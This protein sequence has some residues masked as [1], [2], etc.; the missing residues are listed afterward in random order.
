MKITTKGFYAIEIMRALAEWGKQSP[1][2]LADVEAQT[3][4][5]RSYVALLTLGLKRKGLAASFRGNLA[6]VLRS[7]GPIPSPP[8]GSRGTTSTE[9]A[10]D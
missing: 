8:A 5:P 6:V 9:M 3:G 7:C 2:S 10:C 4:V 1:M